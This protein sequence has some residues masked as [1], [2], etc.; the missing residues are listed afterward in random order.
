MTGAEF[1]TIRESL[2]LSAQA[3]AEILGI[4]QERTVRRW[5]DGTR[6]VPDDAAARLRELDALAERI[7]E[8]GFRVTMDAPDG[9][10]IAVL[11]YET[12]ADFAAFQ[13]AA[14]PH[15]HRIHAA[16]IG[17]LARAAKGRVRIVAM[18]P[19]AYLAW[20]GKRK[21]TSAMRSAWAAEQV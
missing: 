2:G 4:S 21:D 7:C 17:R 6:S 13:G 11:R 14:I 3:L 8:Q 9:A 1:K 16:A 20:L 19:D 5:E 18:Q 12:E 15:M 10:I